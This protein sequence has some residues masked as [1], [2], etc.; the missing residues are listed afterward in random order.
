MKS[1]YDELILKTTDEYARE[2]YKELRNTNFSFFS[3]ST[4][5]LLVEKKDVENVQEW[6]L[7]KGINSIH[8]Q[9]LCVV[10][11]TDETF[12]IHPAW[13]DMD[14]REAL[15]YQYIADKYDFKSMNID[16]HN[17]QCAVRGLIYKEE[18]AFCKEN[19]IHD[20]Y[21]RGKY[22][23]PFLNGGEDRLFATLRVKILNEKG[24]KRIS[25]TSFNQASKDDIS[26]WYG[27][28]VRQEYPNFI[29]N[30]PSLSEQIESASTRAAES[31][32]TS[33][34]NVKEPEHEF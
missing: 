9:S 22:A 8:G 13:F 29:E 19:G 27:V 12:G 5:A 2:L 7:A 6:F 14:S 3:S 20:Y 4:N 21:G 23:S 32:A 31:Q 33:P 1:K 10:K 17:F 30:K 15:I 28:Y 25:R 11:D 34:V 24:Y 16:M 18:Q 26:P